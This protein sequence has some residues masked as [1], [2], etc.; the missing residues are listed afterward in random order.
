MMEG[1]AKEG[2]LKLAI[3]FREDMSRV[4]VSRGHKWIAGWI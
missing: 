2:T 1:N 4:W 3:I